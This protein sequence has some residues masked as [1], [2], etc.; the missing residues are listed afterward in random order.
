MS[1]KRLKIGFLVYA[2]RIVPWLAFGMS[3]VPI[4][5]AIAANPVECECTCTKAG[6]TLCNKLWVGKPLSGNYNC[7][8][9]IGGPGVINNCLWRCEEELYAPPPGPDGTCSY[10]QGKE[11]QGY[12]HPL[13]SGTTGKQSG[14][15]SCKIEPVVRPNPGPGSGTGNSGGGTTGGQGPF[16]PEPFIKH[17]QQ[18]LPKK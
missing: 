10:W 14:I 5:S 15:L 2:L 16:K 13:S 18:P 6:G 9:Q 8:Y 3:V 17:Y 12:G 1:S 4:G 7:S 11:C